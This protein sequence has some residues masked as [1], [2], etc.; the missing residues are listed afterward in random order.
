MWGL[1]SVAPAEQAGQVG[2]SQES[3]ETNLGEELGYGP[4]LVTKRPMLSYVK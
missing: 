2:A 1:G 3:W 4:V